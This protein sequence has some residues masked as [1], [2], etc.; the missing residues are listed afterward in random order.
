MVSLLPVPL[1]ILTATTALHL[2]IL[3]SWPFK[4]K[5]NQSGFPCTYYR[6]MIPVTG[7]SMPFFR[8][9]W[10]A[11]HVKAWLPSVLNIS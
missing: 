6:Q 2:V 7:D 8:E 4:E 11:G 1:K 3:R 9:G 5:G 10:Q